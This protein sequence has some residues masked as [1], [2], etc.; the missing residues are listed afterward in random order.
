M[1]MNHSLM[2][3]EMPSFVTGLHDKTG[4]WVRGLADHFHFASPHGKF[5]KAFGAVDG[6]RANVN[7]LIKDGHDI[8]V[9]P[10]GGQEVLK[11]SSVPKYSLMWKE[12]LGFARLAIKH[13]Y[14]II[15]CAS[16][17]VEDM[18]N[19]VADINVTNIRKDQFIPVVSFAPQRLQ[20]IY[21]WVG[22][23]ISTAEYNGDWKNDNFAR[24]VRDA[25]KS[26]IES[27]IQSLLKRQ[28]SDPDRFLMNQ[29]I[30]PFKNILLGGS[31][32]NE[33]VEETKED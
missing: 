28:S 33:L 8:L 10:G 4:V 29:L 15:P 31:E 3:L 9:Y 5:L 14:Q 18:L 2:G 22:K 16:V 1:G 13:G 30:N 20:K 21:F 26:S 32:C 27:G 12:R 19:V 11:H 7:S 17:G 24:Q 25:A 23:P 6:T